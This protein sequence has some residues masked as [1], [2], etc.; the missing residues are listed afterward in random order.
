M[1]PYSRTVQYYETDQMGI[2]HHSNYIRYFEEARMDLWDQA[3]LDYH[4]MEKEGI[5]I[6]VLACSCRYK[7]PLRF[8]Q[9]FSIEVSVTDFN[10]VRFQVAYRIFAEG[11]ETPSAFGESEHC[12]ADKSM[13]PIRIE[14][15]YPHI[16]EKVQAIT[17]KKN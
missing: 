17:P 3:G 4:Q 15:R 10:G 6:P 9:R 1:K 5:L 13:H 11:E 8:P 12:F 2:V 7:K 16:L 14:K